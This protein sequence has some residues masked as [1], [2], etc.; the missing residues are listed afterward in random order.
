M[1]KDRGTL[2]FVDGIDGSGKSTLLEAL[3]DQIMDADH[4]YYEHYEHSIESFQ[5][6]SRLP[7]S[8]DKADPLGSVLFYLNDFYQTLK[9][10]RRTDG[11]LDDYQL[12]DRS[13]VTTMAYQGFHEDRGYALTNRQFESIFRLGS[14]ALFSNHSPHDLKRPKDLFFLHVKCDPEVAADRIQDRKSDRE[15]AIEK[16]QDREELVERL[17]TLQDR[18]SLCYAYLRL[19]IARMYPM[20][21]VVLLE[22]D[23]TEQDAT[24]LLE[25]TME[26]LSPVIW[27]PQLELF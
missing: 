5:F 25:T 20:Q 3:Q 15:G 16:I 4:H 23:S 10:R 11:K 21:R 27:P 9:G 18:F 22:L 2:V 6:P 19:N 13:F 1:T 17:A 14:E 8:T 24:A 7:S 12:F 26:E